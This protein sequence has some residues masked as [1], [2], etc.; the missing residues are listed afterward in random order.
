MARDQ[1]SLLRAV[2]SELISLDWETSYIQP[3]A[4]GLEFAVFAASWEDRPVAVKAPWSRHIANAN[5]SDQ[6]AR[7]LIRQEAELLKFARSLGVPAPEVVMLHL[8]GA[9]DLLVTT[10]IP[11]DGSQPSGK[12]LAAT[13]ADVH[14]APAPIVPLVGQHGTF[15]ETIAE[16]IV[17][18]VRVAERLSGA[19]LGLPPEAELAAIIGSGDHSSSLL[20]LDVRRANILTNRGQITGLIDWTNALVGD[21]ALEL[22]RIAEYQ[23]A[24]PGFFE[25]YARRRPIATTGVRE[26]IYRLD[27]AVMLALVFLSEA[28]NPAR[29]RP[30]VARASDLAQALRTELG[31]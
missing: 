6:D 13:L 26:L 29:A 18:R 7:D 3:F 21:P 20:H 4:T 17:R 2:Q 28:P 16:R 19:R 9:V 11:N 5:D 8:D 15:S 22:A 25:D 14:A 30:Q 10:L 1:T 12:Q 27:T 24:P 31:S 23:S